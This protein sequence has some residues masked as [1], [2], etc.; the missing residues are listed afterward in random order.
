MGDMADDAYDVALADAEYTWCP[1]CG[2]PVERSPQH[3]ATIG[4][5][6]C[7]VSDIDEDCSAGMDCHATKTETNQ[8]RIYRP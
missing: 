7:G 5:E 2:Y 6:D 4:C 3:G 8:T 1:K